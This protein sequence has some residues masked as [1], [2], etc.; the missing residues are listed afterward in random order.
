MQ[1][2]QIIDHSSSLMKK[3]KK[4]KMVRSEGEEV[5]A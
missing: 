3:N 5:E 2:A 1:V 4:A